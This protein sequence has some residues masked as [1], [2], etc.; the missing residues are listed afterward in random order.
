[1]FETLSWDFWPFWNHASQ[2]VIG[3][4]LGSLIDFTVQ[5]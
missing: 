1:M 4:F 3:N 5:C 2:L